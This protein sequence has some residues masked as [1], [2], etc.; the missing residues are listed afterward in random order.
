MKMTD[1]KVWDEIKRF[2][3]TSIR[4]KIQFERY[5]HKKYEWLAKRQMFE[6][7]D[8][9]NHIALVIGDDC[10]DKNGVYGFYVNKLE[11]NKQ[12]KKHGYDPHLMKEVQQIFG[13]KFISL[14]AR[15]YRLMWR[16]YLPMGFYR[17]GWR[18]V[19]KDF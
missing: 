2:P 6:Y 18:R 9:D 4:L 16:Y 12:F 15:S 13:A 14:R 5:P 10:Y 7:V 3:Y 17:I 8:G 1:E 19:R 11:V